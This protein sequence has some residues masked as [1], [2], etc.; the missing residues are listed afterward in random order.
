VGSADVNDY[1][2]ELS[3]AEFTAK[4]FRTWHA[5]VHALQLLC[6]ICTAGPISKTA[7]NE[8]L[9]EVAKRL[10]NT[11]AVCRKSYV[12]PGLIAA[13]GEAGLA[14]LAARAVKRCRGLSVAECR[15]LAFLSAGPGPRGPRVAAA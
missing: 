12:H 15:L 5:S 7:A 14:E 3:G 4:D 8:V 10:G 2:R 11:L 9:R 6:P 1:L 13:A